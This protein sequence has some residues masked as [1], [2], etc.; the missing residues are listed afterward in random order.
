M[1]CGSV[2][3][4]NEEQQAVMD[5]VKSKYGRESICH[6]PCHAVLTLNSTPLLVSRRTAAAI[7]NR[8]M[9]AD[10]DASECLLVRTVVTPTA[11]LFLH[12][13]NMYCVVL[14]PHRF[15]T[16]SRMGP[17]PARIFLVPSQRH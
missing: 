2:S 1:G 8:F 14:F 6:A 4:L 12:E 7:A 9:A 17:Q 13:G 5:V 10:E 11:R 15:D 16:Q 3:K